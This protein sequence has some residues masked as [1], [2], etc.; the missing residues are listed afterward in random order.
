MGVGQAV[1]VT[2][3]VLLLA[4][5]LNFPVSTNILPALA[6]ISLSNSCLLLASTV[7]RWEQTWILQHIL[8]SLQGTHTIWLSCPPTCTCA[9]SL[10]TPVKGGYLWHQLAISLSSLTSLHTCK[11]AI[12]HLTIAFHACFGMQF[13]FCDGKCMTI[14]LK[15]CACTWIY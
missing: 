8:E 14:T 5:L 6:S 12:S 15:Y 3:S 13:G 7:L 11:Y 1:R 4:N 10:L 2:W 9:Q